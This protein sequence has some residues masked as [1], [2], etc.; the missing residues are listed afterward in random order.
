MICTHRVKYQLTSQLTSLAAV[1]PVAIASM[2]EGLWVAVTTLLGIIFMT[3]PVSDHRHLSTHYTTQAM[4]ESKNTIVNSNV[5]QP[6]LRQKPKNIIYRAGKV[7]SRNDYQIRK[8][9]SVQSSP[10]S[11][12]ERPIIRE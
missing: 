6:M 11:L 12:V 5:V 4:A 7:W 2:M 3:V 8:H 9:C 10:I 1:V